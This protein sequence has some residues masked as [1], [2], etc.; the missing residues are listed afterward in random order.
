[1]NDAWVTIVEQAR[2]LV[3]QKAP[4][5]LLRDAIPFGIICLI[6]GIG[7]S[8][9]G[10]KLGR[11]GIT[12]LFVLL[13]AWV[14]VQFSELTDFARPLCGL[15]GAAMLGIVGYQ[16]FRLWVGLTAG[17]VLASIMAGVFGFQR[18]VPHV[19]EFE[20]SRVWVS[21]DAPG[22]YVV[23]T[24]AQQEAYVARGPR[25]WASELWR[26]VASKD[27]NIAQNGKAVV[28][29]ALLTGLCFGVIALRSALILSTSL[30]GTALVTTA[31]STL[32]YRMLPGSYDAV[33]KNP[34]Y[35]GILVGAF[36]VMSIVVQT[37][38]TRAAPG[39][40]PAAATAKA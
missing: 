11:F 36:L 14:G 13:G 3:Q 18:V 27:A 19:E 40:K 16:S 31:I 29:G 32:T 17:L 20:R 28:L 10:A 30:I 39:D 24:A 6:G 5:D 21:A 12:S 4:A 23:P 1:M 7:F 34:Q 37:L 35:A 22:E 8:V 15:I 25:D 2:Q 9:L 38:L 26:F 33:Q